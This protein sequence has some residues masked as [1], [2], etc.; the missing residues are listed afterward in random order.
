MSSIQQIAEDFIKTVVGVDF[1]EGLTEGLEELEKE[2]KDF[3]CKVSEMKLAEIDEAIF[4]KRKL[5]KNWVVEQKDEKRELLTQF[6]LL[7]FKR[8]YYRN[9]RT[10][11][12]KYLADDLVGLQKRERIEAGL[13]AKLCEA[14]TEN[15]YEK[16]SKICCSGEV[17]RQS[18]MR[19]TR[20]VKDCRLERP[21]VR[22]DV[23]IIH[24][25][26]DE[27]HVAMQDERRDVIVKLAAI[28]E[29]AQRIGKKRWRLPY[30]HL[31]TSYDEPVEDFW[32]RIADE[33]EKRY[34]DINRLKIYIHGDGAGWIRSG[35][36]WILNSRFVLDKYHVKK[37]VKQVTG[38][39][40]GYIQYIMDNFS[41]DDR[42]AINELVE[43]CMGSEI[44]SEETGRKFISYIRS[45]WDGIQIWYNPEE[46]AGRSCAE[47]L[48]SHVLSSRLSS[49]P[50]G[51]LDDG[52]QT[53]SN[54]R[55]HVLNGGKIKPENLRKKHKPV[56]K[57]T[58]ELKK[59]VGSFNGKI[60][61]TLRTDHRSSAQYRLY[62]AITEGGYNF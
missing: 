60:S 51:W 1:C 37:A 8:R 49:R 47:G 17:T 2:T 6:G 31:M 33:I 54:L 27:D 61:D 25:Q 39:D 41:M 15:S 53:I 3:I 38:G 30:R 44:C 29:P 52:V 28:H 34:G 62:K 18:V 24:I 26:A 4:R 16:S 20:K 43:G 50:C 48:V 35:T 19:K 23:K 14:A 36:K 45:N 40:K 7:R 59:A 13:S 58:K 12:Y 32:I 42:K 57:A 22:N 21:E 56:I 9:T 10:G 5:R 55:V 11:K 46:K